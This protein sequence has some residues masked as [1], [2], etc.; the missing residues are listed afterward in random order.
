[1]LFDDAGVFQDPLSSRFESILCR[2]EGYN[3]YEIIA[4]FREDEKDA[5]REIF[6]LMSDEAAPI[7]I[8]AFDCDAMA[9]ALHFLHQIDSS[10]SAQVATSTYN[11]TTKLLT[12]YVCHLNSLRNTQVFD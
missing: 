5:R 1:M 11:L 10:K 2:Q 9:L 7:H 6:D 8:S 4:F 12:V 3:Q